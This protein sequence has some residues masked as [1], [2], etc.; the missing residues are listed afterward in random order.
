MIT[1]LN[2]VCTA[3]IRK[4]F[5]FFSFFNTQK[6]WSSVSRESGTNISKYTV[7]QRAER[8]LIG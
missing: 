1:N 2:T 5:T 8:Q 4:W 3:E 7:K 6:G